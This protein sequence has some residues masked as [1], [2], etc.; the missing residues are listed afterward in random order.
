[1]S[2]SP[3]SVL[4]DEPALL[5][6]VS[7]GPDSTALLLMA[8][9][10]EA[11][12]PKLYAA[13]VDHG[14]RPESAAEAE[15][16]AR[17]CAEAGVP[18]TTLRWEGEK[19]SARLQERAREV[20]YDLLAA[21]ARRVGAH[22]IVTAHHLDD[23]A[24]TVLFRLARGSGLSGLAGM[25]TRTRRGEV[26]IARPLLGVAKAELVA[27]CDARG[28]AYVSDPSNDDPRFARP[29]LRRLA[30]VLAAEGLDAS[31]LAR[32]ARRAAIVEA[33]LAQKTTEAEARLRLA[34]TGR[35]DARALAAEPEEIVRRLLGL[36]VGAAPLDALERIAGALVEA[37]TQRRRFAA[38]VGGALI[39]YDGRAELTVGPEPPRRLSSVRRGSDGAAGQR[40]P[41]DHQSEADPSGKRDALAEKNCAEDEADERHDVIVE[42][43]EGRA[44]PHD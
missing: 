37:V 6:A 33:A 23:Q 12:K 20:R 43:R 40:D 38:N 13:T 4:R 11:P 1:M 22:V 41:R 29:R 7:G 14:L 21:H 36:C 25:A 3:L 2:G 5:L 42:R 16:V 27:L 19:P 34:D 31:A 30:G 8:A 24:E 35:C 10:W 26:E 28:A 17:L 44:H 39:A 15:A 9:E 18:H 32:L